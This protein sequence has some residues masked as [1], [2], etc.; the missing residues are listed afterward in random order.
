MLPDTELVTNHLK[1]DTSAFP[2]LVSKYQHALIH[3]AWTYC[4]NVQDAEDIAQTAFIKAYEALPSSRT[5][6][7]FKP[8]LF[9][10]CINLCKNFLK[11]K[12]SISFSDMDSEEN[13][14]SIPFEDT[15]RSSEPD[16]F[17]QLALEEQ[18]NLVK[19]SMESLPEKF[20]RILSLRYMEQLQ[21]DEISKLLSVPLSTVKT[22]INRAKAHLEKKL[23]TLI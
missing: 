5:D 7:P 6:L 3:L 20:Q 10:I 18:K 9:Q 22:H 13:E 2:D 21:Y 16:P 12:K 17:E 15:I 1:G 11:K 14:Q 8:W 4:K 19:T 23:R